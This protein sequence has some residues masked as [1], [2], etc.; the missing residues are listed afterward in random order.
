MVTN[1]DIC[2]Y[3]EYKIY[4]GVGRR[5]IARD[6]RLHFFVSN[7]ARQMYH[8]KIKAVKLTWTTAWRKFNKKGRTDES[9][10]K[11]TRKTVRVQKSIVGMNIADIKRMKDE[12]RTERDQKHDTAMAEVKARKMKVIQEKKEKMAKLAKSQPKASG[13][14]QPK[15]PMNNQGKKK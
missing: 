12:S 14:K 8:Q 13:P 7:K 4:P 2:S 5:F 10:K 15:A 6:G 11:R 1:T 3:T 9:S